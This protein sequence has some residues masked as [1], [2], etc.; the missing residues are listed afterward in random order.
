MKKVDFVFSIN[1]H[2]KKDFLKEQIK[3]IENFVEGT[4][5]IILNCNDY[6]FNEMQNEN[7]KNVYINPTIINKTYATGTLTQG[8]YSNMLY[9]LNRFVFKYFVILSSRDR[10]YRKFNVNFT[11]DIE[12]FTTPILK[13]NLNINN[14]H[15]KSFSNTLLFKYF[16]KVA[17]SAHEG[18]V[19]NYYTTYKIVKFLK[20]NREIK[21]D[22]FNFKMCVEEFSL[23]TISVNIGN[24]FYYIGNGVYTQDDISKL[25]NKKFT[26]KINRI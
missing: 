22:L 23:Q 17:N 18:L 11:N 16:N 10:F 20:E 19:F 8:I 21:Y 3:N 6:M 13:V 14:W 4:Y 7:I 5:I 15:W 12:L 24:G 9:I 1:V 25:D 26:H 2:E